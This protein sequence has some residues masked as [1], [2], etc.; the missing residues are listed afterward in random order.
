MNRVP[1]DHSLLAWTE[2][3]VSVRPG[4]PTQ[5]QPEVTAQSAVSMELVIGP[6]VLESIEQHAWAAFPEECCGI[7]VGRAEGGIHCVDHARPAPNVFDGDRTRRYELDPSVVFEALWECRRG[8]R[9]AGQGLET[10]CNWSRRVIGFYHS[11]PDGSSVPSQEDGELAWPDKIYLIIGLTD[12]AA[13]AR[14]AWR[15]HP[16]P[17]VAEDGPVGDIVSGHVAGSPHAS[18]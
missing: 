4:I 1:L 15:A 14:R 2:I 16:A 5:A 9:C 17:V 11:H 7:L 8:A 3:P 13:T 6:D 12:R 18:R 10:R